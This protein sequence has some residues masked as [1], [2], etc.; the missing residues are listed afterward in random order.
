MRRDV[1]DNCRYETYTKNR[2]DEAEVSFRYSYKEKKLNFTNYS[3]L[4]NN[5]ATCGWDEGENKLPE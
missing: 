2:N 5:T 1:A 4:I 3:V